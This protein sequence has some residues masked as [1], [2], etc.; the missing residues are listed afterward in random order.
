MSGSS[1]RLL[2][3][4]ALAAVVA[5][6]IGTFRATP[7]LESRACAARLAGAGRSVAWYV[8]AD[9]GDGRALDAWCVGVGPV[10]LDTVPDGDG[11]AGGDSLRMLVWNVS[12]GGGDLEGFL[13]REAGLHCAS[14]GGRVPPFVLMAQEVYR[15]SDQVPRATAGTMVSLRAAER[16]RPGA[17]E[18]VTV[19]ARR[20]GLALF[21]VPAVRNGGEE[22]PDG[23]EDRGNALLANVTLHDPIAIE[24]PAEDS[25]RLAIGATVRSPAGDSVR[26][27]T[28]HFTLLPKLW[29]NLTTG[30]A[31]RVRHALGMLDALAQVESARG[32][33]GGIATVAAGDA[34]VWSH[35]DAALRR[36]REA[37][38]DSPEA[39]RGGTRGPF[40]ADHLLFRR[41]AGEGAAGSIVPGSY[42][43]FA[44]DYNSDHRPLGASYRFAP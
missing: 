9:A 22:F 6:C 21:Y 40:P 10:V 34:N 27:V 24:L 37:F 44:S 41:A 35:N 32:S 25:R 14:P 31:A 3:V 13:E 39:V 4:A 23:R 30:N 28:M 5:G 26:L 36:L 8:P 33:A 20:C 42:R 18:D 11:W 19:I 38:P 12:A 16:S 1:R 15:R 43:H 2:G 7:A 17:R 29:R